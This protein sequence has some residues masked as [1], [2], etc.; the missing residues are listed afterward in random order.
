MTS[1]HILYIPTIF[2]LGLITGMLVKPQNTHANV[3]SSARHAV[4]GRVLFGSLLVFIF[5][6]FGTHFFSIPRSAHAVHH[7]LNGGEIFDKKPSFTSEEVYGRI[8]KFPQNGIFLYK[9]FTYTTDILFP[10]TFLVFLVLVS[11]YISQRAY[12]PKKTQIMLLFI[13][14]S[15]FALDMIENSMIFHILNILPSKSES[16]ASVLGFVT[17]AKFTL[18]LFSISSPA[19]IKTFEKSLIR[20]FYPRQKDASNVGS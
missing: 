18:L 19:F 15:W 5:V 9:Q 20:E 10:I 2:L 8:D 11:L 1:A 4:S 16:L 17:I 14:L 13:P 3:T 6:F 7:A 12:L